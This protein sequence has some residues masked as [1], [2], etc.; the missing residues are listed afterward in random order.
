MNA[1]MGLNSNRGCGESRDESG[2][3]SNREGCYVLEKDKLGDENW[4]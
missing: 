1:V 3:C 4:Q 2:E